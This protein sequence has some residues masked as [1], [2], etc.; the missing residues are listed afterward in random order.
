[1]R[2]LV[3]EILSLQLELFHCIYCVDIMLPPLFLQELKKRLVK[4]RAE[5]KDQI[6]EI[7]ESTGL[8]PIHHI[9]IHLGTYTN[10]L[11]LNLLTYGNADVDVKAS[12]GKTA[13]ML[14]VEVR[15]YSVMLI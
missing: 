14:A 13:L 4:Y 12:D 5:W 1:M 2:C 8:A 11:L 3:Y 7:D 6:N 10:L 15:S 9:A